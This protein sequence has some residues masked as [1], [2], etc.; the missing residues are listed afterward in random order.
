MIFKADQITL[1][2]SS[3]LNFRWTFPFGMF[4]LTLCCCI[5][6]L[7]N[8]EINLKKTNINAVNHNDLISHV[9]KHVFVFVVKL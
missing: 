1:I 2:M 6:M 4:H 8:E 9:L 3:C 5:K 7:I